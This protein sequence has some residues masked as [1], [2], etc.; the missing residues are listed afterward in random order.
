MLNV[1]LKY[2]K[3]CCEK[4]QNVVNAIIDDCPKE[5]IEFQFVIKVTSE[6]VL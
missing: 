3:N 1:I 6:T 2:L 4:V 5:A